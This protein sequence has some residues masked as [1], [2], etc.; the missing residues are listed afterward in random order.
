M[1]K[2]IKGIPLPSGTVHVSAPAKVNLYL[3]VLGR[4]NDGY[5]LL[6]SL[7]AFVDVG[8][9]VS[10]RAAEGLSF[11]IEGPFAGQL[12]GASDNLVIR[13]ANLLAQAAGVLPN[14]ALTLIK[15]LPVAS[16][17]GGGSSDAAA[18]LRVLCT[19]WKLRLGR[20]E[21][22]ELALRLGADVPVC[23][24]GKPAFMGGIGEDIMPSPDLGRPWMVL[25]NPGVGVSTPEVFAARTGAFSNAARFGEAL[26]TPEALAALLAERRNDLA[27]PARRHAPLI[28][29]VLA[30]LSSRPGCLL[31]RMTGSG[32]TCFGLFTSEEAARAAAMGIAA[33][34]PRWWVVATRLL[35]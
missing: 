14:A 22:A 2:I 20:K 18:T 28:D 25:A 33:V 23:L 35:S 6:D 34:R 13:A 8:D 29:T 11:S 24:F 17:V 27:D 15:R 31:A 1:R 7:V 5:H 4:R 30:A 12:S 9:S 19:L 26:E 10:A 3:H 32:A 21:M 16:G